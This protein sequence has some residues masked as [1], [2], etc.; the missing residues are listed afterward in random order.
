MD[1]R[2]DL[3]GVPLPEE[4]PGDPGV[5]AAAAGAADPAVGGLPLEP[6]PEAIRRLEDEVAAA[7]DRHLRLAAEYDNYRKRAA[8]EREELTHRSQA[9]L[10][11]RLL[12]VLDDLDRVL[13]G[14]TTGSGDVVQQALVMIDRKLRKELEAAGLERIDP[15]GQPFDP[16]IAEAVSVIAPPAAAQDHTV[17]ATFQAGYRFKG[18]LI[19]PARVQVYSAEGHA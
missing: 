1:D 5:G 19:R 9:A 10:A 13:A 15:A 16:A 8:R 2:Q 7:R 14:A 6:A 17:A 11:V 4:T 18:G 3:E 12:D